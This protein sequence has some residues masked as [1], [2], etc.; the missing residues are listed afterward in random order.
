[1]L[2][3]VP[4]FDTHHVVTKLGGHHLGELQPS[5]FDVPFNLNQGLGRVL[6]PEHGTVLPC[7][8]SAYGGF[9]SLPLRLIGPD[10]VTEGMS[11]NLTVALT[12]TPG[13]GKTQ[14]AGA[15]ERQGWQIVNVETAANDHG[16]LG[17]TEA[18]GAAPVDVHKLSASWTSPTGKVVVDGHL[19]HFLD[20]NAVVL[21]RCSP[22]L[23]RDRLNARDYSEAK[24]KANVEWE[25]TA[26]HWAELLEFE[27]EVPVLELDAGNLS[28]ESLLTEV[29]AWLD[30]GCPAAPLEQAA[31]ESVDWLSE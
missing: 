13:V 2:L 10:D 29:L 26:G 6:H 15:F 19:S 5:A 25:L 21:L 8:A 12:G 11:D 3:R 7:V 9:A 4:F 28:T 17:D 1:M 14:L 20:V 30:N 31:S 18:D 27:I 23:L 22:H 16:C 24:T